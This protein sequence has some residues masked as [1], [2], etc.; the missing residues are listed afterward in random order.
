MLTLIF[1]NSTVITIKIVDFTYNTDCLCLQFYIF[2][3][4]TAANI[5]RFTLLRFKNENDLKSTA[6]SFIQQ[7]VFYIHAVRK[8]MG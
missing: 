5:K 7:A 4:F 1:K 2:Y 3:R 6:F 8:F